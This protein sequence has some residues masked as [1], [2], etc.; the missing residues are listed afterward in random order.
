MRGAST[1]TGASGSDPVEAGATAAPA[2]GAAPGP[3]TGTSAGAAA[4]DGPA[5]AATPEVVG[6]AAG[7]PSPRPAPA[8]RAPRA[9]LAEAQG[10][11]PVGGVLER[12]AR[13]RGL[14]LL[15]VV[16]VVVLLVVA[17]VAV[18]GRGEDEQAAAAPADGVAAQQTLALALTEAG[19]GGLV[20]AALMAVDDAAVSTLLVPED[21]LLTVADAGELSVA[22]AAVLGAA[23]V[24]RGVED[25]LGVRVDS[26]LLLR[27]AQLA[28]LV[29][30]AGGVVVDVTAQVVTEDV[31]VPVGEDQRLT[32]AQAVAYA[33][34][35]VDG[36]PGE[37]RLARLG[38][39]VQALLVALPSDPD[40]AAPVLDE[41]GLTGDGAAAGS[42][43]D[44]TTGE[45][46]AGTGN[47]AEPRAD[48]LPGL[49]AEAAA[50]AD[51]GDA[52]QLVLPTTE[53]AVGDAT[54][55][56]LD[57]DVAQDELDGRFAGAALP[58]SEVGEVRVVLRNAV[59]RA[60]LGAAARDLLVADGLRYVGG[61]NVEPFGQQPTSLVLVDSQDADDRA[62]GEA[63][64]DALG[65]PADALQVGQE[66]LVDTDVVVVLGDDFAR[67]TPS[68]TTG[69]TGTT[70]GTPTTGAAP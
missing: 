44:A 6:K 16:L 68:S 66:T 67:S 12:L 31:V 13:P 1:G 19:G 23:A 21:L 34:L 3:A 43:D 11:G 4:T 54:R 25:T 32:G 52:E 58:V 49:L 56:A 69:T 20:G 48:G 60:G 22:E 27:P 59:G 18:L 14:L 57:T 46:G 64:A 53:L 63:V 39:V 51:D 61:G 70:A 36:E 2:A 50:R 41:A 33:G 55:R 62:A 47:D 26:A 37:A 9:L 35:A 45:T 7:F 5:D 28:T 65:L 15:A 30:G 17:L 8:S 24:R 42:R 38:S 29:D 10:R 40:A